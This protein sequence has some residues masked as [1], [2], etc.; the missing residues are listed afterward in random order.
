MSHSIII[1]AAE[2]ASIL[3]EFLRVSVPAALAL[4]GV[5]CGVRWS[6]RSFYSQKWWEKKADAYLGLN[7]KIIQL[8]S[9]YA[10]LYR[11]KSEQVSIED[12]EASEFANLIIDSEG[13]AVDKTAEAMLIESQKDMHKRLEE[14][15]VRLEKLPSLIGISGYEMIDYFE[16]NSLLFSRKLQEQEKFLRKIGTSYYHNNRYELDIKQMLLYVKNEVNNDLQVAKLRH[17]V[18]I[19]V[20]SSFKRL[21]SKFNT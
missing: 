2:E 21:Y 9:L 15:R 20:K 19:F 1:K 18:V 5:Y 17:K 4:L 16:A 7:I 8:R 10:E 11:L 6:L 12:H 3:L 13:E 14:I